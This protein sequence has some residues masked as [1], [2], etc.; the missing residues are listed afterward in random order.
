MTKRSGLEELF[1]RI[2]ELVFAEFSDVVA[3]EQL[4]F[5]SSGAMRSLYDACR[6]G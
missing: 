1:N 5:T 2:I 6:V 3:D 4:R